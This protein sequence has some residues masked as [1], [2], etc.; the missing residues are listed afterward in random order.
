MC[1]FLF[2][3]LFSL[4]VIITQ[5]LKA[6]KITS[7]LTSSRW[8][9]VGVVFL[10]KG[11]VYILEVLLFENFFLFFIFSSPILSDSFFSFSLIHFLNPLSHFSL[12]SLSLSL[13][14]I[15][16]TGV[17]LQPITRMVNVIDGG[18]TIG[19][20]HLICAR[21]RTFHQR[22]GGYIRYVFF[23]VFFMFFFCFFFLCFFFMFFFYVFFYV[24]FLCFFL[25]FFY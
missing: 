17:T 15:L 9:H 2:P 3:F 5:I 22:L 6:S 21:S 19:I 23:Y 10:Q 7:V 18:G 14:A 25:C 13:Q 11:E 12:F 1:F 8:D 24:F 4:F 16:E 20:R